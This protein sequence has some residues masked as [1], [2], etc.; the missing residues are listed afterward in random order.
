[1][2]YGTPKLL[3]FIIFTYKVVIVFGKRSGVNR[4]GV[5]FRGAKLTHK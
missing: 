2:T 4:S 3:A 5:L 1:M